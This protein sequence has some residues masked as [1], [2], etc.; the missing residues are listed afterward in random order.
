MAKLPDAQQ[1]EAITSAGMAV[2]NSTASP[3]GA[4]PKIDGL[5]ATQ[6]DTAGEIDLS[7]NPIKRGLQNYLIEPTDDPTGQTAWR[8]AANSR[9]STATLNGLTSEKRYWFRVTAEGA[10]DP[11]PASEPT[12]KVAP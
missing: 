10:G 2:A 9:K 1:A 8:F 11:S 4:L 12:T 5:T 6:G 7:W 3:V